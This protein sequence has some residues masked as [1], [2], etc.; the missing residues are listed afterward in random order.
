MVLGAGELRRLNKRVVVVQTFD[1]RVGDDQP[2]RK[3]AETEKLS[4]LLILTRRP[5]RQLMPPQ[6]EHFLIRVTSSCFASN[7][8]H[9]RQWE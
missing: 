3:N 2:C 1:F 7:K 5:Q 4:L 8:H 9:G 6:G